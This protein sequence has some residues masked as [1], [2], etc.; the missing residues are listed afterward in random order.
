MA[1]I[2]PL[3]AYMSAS[4]FDMSF[5]R[6]ARNAISELKGKIVAAKKADKKSVS[7][8]MVDAL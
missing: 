1:T 3:E 5:E 2:F 7:S 4:D 8:V 6:A